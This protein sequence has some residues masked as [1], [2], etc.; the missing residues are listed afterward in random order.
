VVNKRERQRET[1]RETERQRQTDRE[2]DRERD[3]DR[4]REVN[5]RGEREVKQEEGTDLFLS[6]IILGGILF[7]LLMLPIGS[8]D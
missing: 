7:A 5:K 6:E 4:Q 1:G 2:R 3:R 8:N